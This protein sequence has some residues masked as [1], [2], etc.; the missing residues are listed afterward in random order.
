MG[1]NRK[2][3]SIVATVA[4]GMVV[5]WLST[6]WGQGRSNY[7]AE[8]RV[9]ATPEYQTDTTRAIDA[10]EKLMQRYMDAAEHNFNGLSTDVKAMAAKLNT[11]DA[12]LTSLD[13]RLARIE[14]H[15]GIAAQAAGAGDPNAPTVLPQKPQPQAILDVPVT[16]N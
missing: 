7:Q 10:Y 8:T 3:S 5:L 11:V 4:L 1:S 6:S 2:L 13:A 14:K 15:L 12:K 9:Y 16:V